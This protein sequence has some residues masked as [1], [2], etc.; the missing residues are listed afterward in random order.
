[1][2]PAFAPRC[3]DLPSD[4][5]ALQTLHSIRRH[6]GASGYCNDRI[7][8]IRDSKNQMEIGSI[9]DILPAGIHPFFL[10]NRLTHG[11]SSGAAGIIMDMNSTAVFTDADI[12]AI[13]PVL[14]FMMFWATFACSGEGVYFSRYAG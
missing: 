5:G 13:C 4:R 10:R 8:K 6:K 7:Q 9:Q 2:Y 12:C 11:D 1:M 14:Q 3:S